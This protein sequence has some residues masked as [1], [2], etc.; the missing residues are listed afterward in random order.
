MQLYEHQSGVSITMHVLHP[1]HIATALNAGLFVCMEDGSV[2][3]SGDAAE[4]RF[5]RAMTPFFQG[6]YKYEKKTRINDLTRCQNG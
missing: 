1:D 2:T 6:R 3:F 4:E 5:M